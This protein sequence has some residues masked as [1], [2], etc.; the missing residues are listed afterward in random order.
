MRRVGPSGRVGKVV[1]VCEWKIFV[2]RCLFSTG[3]ILE[4]RLRGSSIVS[5]NAQASIP[6]GLGTVWACPRAE[7]ELWVAYRGGR[8]RWETFHRNNRFI[9]SGTGSAEKGRRE[10]RGPRTVICPGL[11][12]L[13]DE[14]FG[15]GG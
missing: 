1:S 9:R 14:G 13:G 2:S 3:A 15:G 10:A 5:G 6:V 11:R 7:G 8:V 12:V 4:S